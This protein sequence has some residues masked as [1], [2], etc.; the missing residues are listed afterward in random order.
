MSNA[1]PID[2]HQVKT[3]G[4]RSANTMRV[5]RAEAAAGHANRRMVIQ[6]MDERDDVAEDVVLVLQVPP[7]ALARVH[8]PVVPALAVHRR[9]AEQLQRAV[10]ELAGERA[11]HPLVL[12]LE[13]RAHRRGKHDH[14]RAGVA[15]D[16][17]IHVAVERRARTSL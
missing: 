3:Y 14:R 11:H 12:V 6:M 5:V 9:D 17:Q 8:V 10:F 13:E 16:Q 4:C 2:T 15:E 7:H 1:P